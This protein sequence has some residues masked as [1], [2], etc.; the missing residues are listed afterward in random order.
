M[1]RVKKT[2]HRRREKYVP[3]VPTTTDTNCSPFCGNVARFILFFIISSD[4]FPPKIFD[5]EIDA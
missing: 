1:C 5:T 4:V 2:N 3:F